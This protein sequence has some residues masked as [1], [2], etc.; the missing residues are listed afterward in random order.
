MVTAGMVA[1]V[2]VPLASGAGVGY[3]TRRDSQGDWYRALQKPPWTPPGWLFG[4]VWTALYIMMGLALWRV[5]R[6]GEWGAV[7]MFG[8][9]L[10][11]NLSW[12]LVFFKAKRPDWALANILALLVALMATTRQFYRVDKVAGQLL[13]PYL[14]WVTYAATLN[15]EIVRR[16]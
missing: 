16:N 8:V 1:T 15:A 14:A 9:Q 10:A 4:P 11:L 6:A 2:A 12:S 5:V 3:A 13:L 7:A